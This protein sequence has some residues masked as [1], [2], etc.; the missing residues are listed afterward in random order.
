MTGIDDMFNEFAGWEQQEFDF[1]FAAE[2]TRARTLTTKAETERHRYRRLRSIPAQRA[3]IRAYRSK[4]VTQ[5][6]SNRLKADPIWAA[7]HRRK[8]AAAEAKRRDAK[9]QIARAA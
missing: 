7:E 6:V 4:Q 8:R 1:F 9:R 3:V 2:Q 5:Y